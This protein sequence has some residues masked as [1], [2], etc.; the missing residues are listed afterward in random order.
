MAAFLDRAKSRVAD[1][2]RRR[3]VL[4]HV[5]RMQ[6]HFSAVGAAQQAGGITYYAFLSFFP[7]LALAV[8][9]VGL[10]SYVYPQADR[11]LQQAV[12]AVVPGIIG[13]G[14]NELSLE[15]IETFRGRAAVF[16]FVG[17][18]YTGLGW[19]SA[20]RNALEL[21]FERPAREQPGFVSG[22]VRDLLTLAVLGSVLFVA[23][24][25]SQLVGR[26]AE[27]ILDWL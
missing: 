11:T 15:E 2:R 10:L 3:P 14:R 24:A 1:V 18:L 20:L 22:K 17:V 19:I 4:D 16:G 23:V 13:S 7:V 6:Q 12:D 26:S 27:A 21:V 5:F 25:L 8:F 9:T